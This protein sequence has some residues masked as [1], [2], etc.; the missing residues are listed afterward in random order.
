MNETADSEDF[1]DPFIQELRAIKTSVSEEH[2][3]DVGQLCDHL[4]KLQT[5]YGDRIVKRPARLRP[6]TIAD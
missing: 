4:Q 2:G 1:P 3:N 5:E 6:K